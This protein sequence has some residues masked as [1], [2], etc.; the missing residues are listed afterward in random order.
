MFKPE[1]WDRPSIAKAMG[2]SVK[3]VDKWRE[4]YDDFPSPAYHF[5]AGPVWF[6]DEVREW[7][8]RKVSLRR[9]PGRERAKKEARP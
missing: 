8:R 6:A 1:L 3:A 9:M 5:A 4:V 7:R 2:V